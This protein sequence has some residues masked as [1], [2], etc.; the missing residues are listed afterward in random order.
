M[1]ANYRVYRRGEHPK[2]KRF[3]Y[4][5]T[6]TKRQA[7]RVFCRNRRWEDGLTIVHPGGFEEPFKLSDAKE[8]GLI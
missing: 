5:E 1:E 6:F 3:F 4:R 2:P 7:A 8:V